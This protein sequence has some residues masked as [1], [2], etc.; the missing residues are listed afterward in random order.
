MDA[1]S[2]VPGVTRVPGPARIP[3]AHGVWFGH[4]PQFLAALD[5]WA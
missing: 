5:G 3:G 4:V 2:E 1:G